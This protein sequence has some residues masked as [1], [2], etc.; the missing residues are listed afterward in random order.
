[1][2]SLKTE[3]RDFIKNFISNGKC[4][5]GSIWDTC[6]YEDL[7]AANL[8]MKLQGEEIVFAYN[9][10]TRQEGERWPQLSTLRP[11][12][13]EAIII[14]LNS[15]FPEGS[16][17][18]FDVLIP[19]LLPNKIDLITEYAEKIKPL[20]D[21]FKFDKTTVAIQFAE[22]LNF[23]ISD[24]NNEFCTY[25]K[26]D[27]QQFWSHFLSSNLLQWKT[28]IKRLITIVLIL[29]VGTSNVERSFSVLNHFK[30]S[31][32]SRLTPKHVQDITRI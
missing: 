1:M 5:K 16:L 3:N 20:A 11:Q 8:K 12:L 28:Q 10:K 27:A 30:S 24:M 31:R 25:T 6:T 23:M 22:I 4:L 18:I 32:R 7:N 29:P 17:N 26:H 21:H 13:I 9:S 14:E 19:S 2:K 15:Y